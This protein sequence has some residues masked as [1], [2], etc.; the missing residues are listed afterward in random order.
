MRFKHR[1]C[2]LNNR[3]ELT[4]SYYLGLNRT[5]PSR[6]KSAQ[7][8]ER[9]RQLGDLGTRTNIT[10]APYVRLPGQPNIWKIAGRA[11]VIDN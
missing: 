8:K 7:M 1:Y 2:L 3:I 11:R 6:L 10:A 9:V 4:K 5:H